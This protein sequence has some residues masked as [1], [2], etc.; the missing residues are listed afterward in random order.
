MSKPAPFVDGNRTHKFCTKCG[1]AKPLSDFYTTGKTVSNG[2]KYN[3]WCKGCIAKKQASYHKQTWGLEKLHKVAFKRT[4]TVRAYLS[5]LR[6]KA[7]ARNKSQE[8]I[9]VDALELLWSAQ[10]GKCALTGW[11]MTTELGRGTVPTNCSIDR[12][13]SGGGYEVGNVQLVCRAANVAKND[14]SMSSFIALCRSVVEA[15]RD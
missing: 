7:L 1:T 6:G 9:S 11:D 8:V 10:A 3:S 12:I 5:Y 4:K 15:N 14:L 2:P 13:C